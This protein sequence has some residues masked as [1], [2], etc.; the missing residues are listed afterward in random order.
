MTASAFKAAALASAALI[1]LSFGGGG[2]AQSAG[3][4]QLEVTITS[5]T[6][7][8][9]HVWV[10]VYASEA[11]WDAQIETA[12]ARVAVIEGEARWVFDALPAGALGLQVFHDANDNGDFDR[13]MMG[14]PSERYGFSNDPLPRFRGARWSE[15][16]FTLAPGA[17]QSVTIT[18]QGVTG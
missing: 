15:A 3:T 10:G 5:A 18:L 12:T 16:M 13:N 4:A 14:V 1:A 8:Q 11:D 6:Q 7:D 17:S 2:H 9:G